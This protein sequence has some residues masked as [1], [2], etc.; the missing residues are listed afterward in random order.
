MEFLREEEWVKLEMKEKRKGE[1][2]KE[3]GEGSGRLGLEA[4]GEV[5]KGKSCKRHHLDSGVASK[6]RQMRK[7]SWVCVESLNVAKQGPF[8]RYEP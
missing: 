5:E 2:K 8:G 7:R 1:V 3:S 4:N 6:R